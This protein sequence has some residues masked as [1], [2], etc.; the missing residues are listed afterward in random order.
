MALGDRP[1]FLLDFGKRAQATADK[2][3]SADPQGMLP[4]AEPW[5]QGPGHPTLISDQRRA[6]GKARSFR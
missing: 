3:V 4:R 2:A 1:V 5:R 6:A